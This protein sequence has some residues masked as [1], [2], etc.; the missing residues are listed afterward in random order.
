MELERVGWSRIRID[1]DALDEVER[2]LR[3]RGVTVRPYD[4]SAVATEFREFLQLPAY[5][6]EY[7]L[8]GGAEEYCLAEKALEHFISLKLIQP[9]AGMTG[10]D[11]GSCRSVV[12]G[13][14]RKEFQCRCY[15]Q[16]LE[17]PSGVH[18]DRVGSSAADIPLE[19][20]SV[21]FMTLHCTFEHFEGDAD[22]GFI[23]ECARLLKPGGK[24]VILPLYV[25]P[26]FCNITG[27]GDPERQEEIGFDGEASYRCL[28]PE[29]QNRF[30]R[31]YSPA[32]LFER[33]I[34]PAAAAGLE[35]IVYRATS[36]E[37]IDPRLWLRWI[38]VFSQP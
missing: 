31:H 29:W 36:W 22:T 20:G 32:A 34:T 9:Q 18:G 6:G 23:R 7:Q 14:L 10:V 21:D 2:D 30:G 16:D 26:N 12:P 13:I 4:V 33:V 1:D 28:I 38:A 27:E 5:Q 35:T 3:D 8:Y 15:E 19:A 11:I 37:A 17:Y 24:V 25:N